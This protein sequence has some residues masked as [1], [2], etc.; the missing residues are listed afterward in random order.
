MSIKTHILHTARIK[1]NCPTCF[2]SEGLEFKFT[3]E[4]KETPFYKKCNP[5]ITENLFCNT[6]NNTIYPVNWKD[7]LERVYE[8]HKKL[9]LPKSSA[10]RLKTISF[11]IIGIGIVVLVGLVVAGKLWF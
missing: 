7:D 8:Y 10:L 3:Q 2:G 11:I 6:C 9:A 4:E 1:N 5:K